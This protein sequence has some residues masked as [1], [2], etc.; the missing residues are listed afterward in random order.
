M[1]ARST[2]VVAGLSD[3]LSRIARSPGTIIADLSD[4]PTVR[5]PLLALG[6]RCASGK[7]A[8]H[9]RTVDHR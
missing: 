2:R 4:R 6:I 8:F 5:S 3:R 7:I 1:I 9:N